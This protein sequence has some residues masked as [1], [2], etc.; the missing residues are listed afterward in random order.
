MTHGS[1]LSNFNQSGPG[2]TWTCVNPFVDVQWVCAIC[3]GI[4]ESAP[5]CEAPVP[6]ICSSCHRLA[7]AEALAALGV[8]R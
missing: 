6:P 2:V 4:E 3:E 7:V 8:R 1:K 5:D